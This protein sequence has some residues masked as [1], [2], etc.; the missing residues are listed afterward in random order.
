[1]PLF[2]P[3][4]WAVTHPRFSKSSIIVKHSGPVFLQIN[5]FGLLAQLGPG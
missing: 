2:A 4:N 1:M 5:T 3:Q